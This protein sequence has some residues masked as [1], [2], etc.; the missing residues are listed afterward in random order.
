MPRLG[1]AVEDGQGAHMRVGFGAQPRRGKAGEA[2]TC[3][4]RGRGAGRGGPASGR[5]GFGAQPR[6]K[7]DDRGSRA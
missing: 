1:L 6:L 4:P 2:R 7:E 3:A 5:V